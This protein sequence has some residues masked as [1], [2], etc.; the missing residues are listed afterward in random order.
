MAETPRGIAHG[1]VDVRS[2]V[3]QIR[4]EGPQG[5]DECEQRPQVRRDRVH[6]LCRAGAEGFRDPKATG[7]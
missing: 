7:R 4:A 1:G 6:A 2:A 5:V 3:R